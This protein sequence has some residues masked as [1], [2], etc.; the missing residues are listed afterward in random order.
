MNS[1]MQILKIVFQN[2]ERNISDILIILRL[3][4]ELRFYKIEENSG[5]KTVTTQIFHMFF[6]SFSSKLM[7]LEINFKM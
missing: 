4:S 7:F 1:E 3:K 2:S 6:K 5:G